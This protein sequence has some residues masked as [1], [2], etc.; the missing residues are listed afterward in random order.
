M[1]FI[2]CI[3]SITTLKYKALC[4]GKNLIKYPVQILFIAIFKQTVIGHSLSIYP[5]CIA[6][7]KSELYNIT[8][9]VP[10]A[11]PGSGFTIK[12]VMACIAF[13]WGRGC[14]PNLNEGHLGPESFLIIKA[15][16]L[17]PVCVCRSFYL[18]HHLFY[19]IG[20]PAFG[21]NYQVVC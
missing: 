11:N 4:F 8:Y 21:F 12:C 15:S 3:S 1:Y 2:H 5:L 20:L 17:S 18:T 16:Y 13:Q 10:G 14:S 19:V 6:D 9:A 7:L